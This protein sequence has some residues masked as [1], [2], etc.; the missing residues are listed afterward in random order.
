MIPAPLRTCASQRLIREKVTTVNGVVKVLLSRVA[1]AL[2]VLRR[3]DAALRAHRMRTFHG[4]DR[5][6][7][8]RNA[9]LGHTNRSHQPGK[10]S[11]HDNNFRLS[12]L[13]VT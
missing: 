6:K 3:I 2:L 7:L 4:N 5:E 13:E 8:H 12:H 1:F 9:R 10:T 11:A